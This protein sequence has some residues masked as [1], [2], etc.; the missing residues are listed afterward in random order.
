MYFNDA[1]KDWTRHVGDAFSYLAIVYRFEPISGERIG[2]TS[3]NYAGP[4]RDKDDQ[5]TSNLLSVR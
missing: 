3:P 1:V 4:V 5:G 2:T